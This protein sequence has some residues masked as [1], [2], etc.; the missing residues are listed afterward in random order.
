[1]SLTLAVVVS[2]EVAEGAALRSE[3]GD[4]GVVLQ[5]E[6]GVHLQTRDIAVTDLLEKNKPIGKAQSSGGENRRPVHR[7]S[8][9]INQTALI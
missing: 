3:P 2:G 5:R 6:E 9:T 7:A 1:M 8:N 4:A